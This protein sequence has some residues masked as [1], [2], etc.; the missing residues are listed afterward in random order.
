MGNIVVDKVDFSFGNQKVLDNISFNIGAG[1][2]L[3]ILGPSG[4]GKSTL[5]RLIAGLDYPDSGII[6]IDN[7]PVSGPGLDRG[8]VF[9]DYSLFPW[10]TAFENVMLSLEQA[11]PNKKKRELSEAAK[12]YL[13][14]VGLRESVN[15]LPKQLSGGM[16]Q[17]AAI[18]SAFAINSPI[19][20]MDEP[21]GA[22]DAI[23]RAHLQ[24]LLLQLWVHNGNKKTIVFVTHDVDEALLMANKILILSLNPG[25]VKSVIN[26]D[27]KRPRIRNELYSD[28]NFQQ[29]R[30]QILN[31]LN[32][33]ILSELNVGQISGLGGDNI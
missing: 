23:T 14:L 19:L 28:I 21:F 13:E 1:D 20:L 3:C 26:V 31:L 8:V 22:L 10:M 24:D 11:F 7:K 2:C 6:Q 29:L 25:R 9:Q 17:R 4:C 27:L 5:L 15:K 32:E 12:E 30:S 18:A 33:S 16:R